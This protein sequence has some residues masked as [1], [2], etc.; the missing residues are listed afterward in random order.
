MRRLLLL[1]VAAALVMAAPAQASFLKK[2]EI[3]SAADGPF[4]ASGAICPSGQTATTFRIVLRPAATGVDLLV[5]K[6]L[7]CDDGSGTID[8]TLYVR[9][10]FFGGDVSAHLVWIVTGG[11]GQYERLQ[12]VGTAVADFSSGEIVD[13]YVGMAGTD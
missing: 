13:H 9:V 6:T 5:G 10:R 12:G 1:G 2:V 11:T 8:L 4:T 7:T 3:T